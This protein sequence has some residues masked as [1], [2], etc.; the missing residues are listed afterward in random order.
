MI[1]LVL[2]LSKTLFYKDASSKLREGAKN[3]HRGEGLKTMINRRVNKVQY[4]EGGTLGSDVTL[5]SYWPLSM[6]DV[7]LCT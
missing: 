2:P 4:M 6:F 5:C 3:T 7:R 1:F